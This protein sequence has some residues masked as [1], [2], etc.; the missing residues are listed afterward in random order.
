MERGNALFLG[1]V[2]MW[3]NPIMI[4][5][6]QS[7]LHGILSGHMMVINYRGRKS[8][9]AYQIPIGYERV[10]GVLMTIS[11]KHRTWWRNLRGGVPVSIRLLGM[12]VNGVAS[13]IEDET[14]VME[15][16]KA[17]FG[18]N[19]RTARMFGV[20]VSRDGEPE[21]ESLKLAAKERCVVRTILK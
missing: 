2:L 17:F 21:P 15:G 18:G 8:G 7:P 5:L 6:L 10:E 13:V 1:G 12:D 19:P 9:K 4:W 20:K 11:Y 14:G 3:Y 16:M